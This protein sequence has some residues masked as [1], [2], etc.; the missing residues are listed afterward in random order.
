VAVLGRHVLMSEGDKGRTLR[1]YDP[2]SGADVWK[3]EYPAAGTVLLKTLDPET[4]GV[5]S[6]DGKFEV[7]QTRTGKSLFKGAVDADR[8]NAHMKTASG[9]MAVTSPVLLADADRYY[10]FLNRNP[11]AGRGPVVYGYSMIRSLPVNGAAYAF[12]K[13]TGKRLWFHEVFKNQM[14]LLERFDELP[15]IVAAAQV[16]DDE[17]KQ[18]QY[19]V[20]VLDK[21]FG[22][23]R[24]NKGHSQNGFFMTVMSDPKTRAVEFFRYDLRLRIVP[25]DGETA[26]R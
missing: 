22:K 14:I 6:P 16:M 4:T 26:S 8:V 15:C 10:V 18:Y 5:L 9:A 7:L 23:L 12:D 1:L 21:Q 25:D 13:A 20:V 17:S 24:Y 2:L 11:D 3:K 19:R